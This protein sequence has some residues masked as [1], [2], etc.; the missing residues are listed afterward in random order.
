[1]NKMEKD[2][3]IPFKPKF[4]KRF[5]DDI[6]RRRKRNEPDELFDKMNSYHPNIKLTI[7]I[8]LKKFFDTK[9]LRSSN[10]IHCFMYHKENKKLIHWN[11]AV[12]KSYKRNV[13]IGDVHHAKRISCDFD[14]ELSVIKLKYIKAGYPPKFVSS[15]INTC[16]VEK[17]E[18]IIRPQMF[19]ERKTVYFQLTFC[20]TNEQKIKSIVNKLEEFTTNKVKFICHW[21]TR[22]LKSLFLLNDRI[23]RKANIVY[24]RI[25][26]CKE[27]YIGETKRNAE[28][29]MERTLF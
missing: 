7:E 2:V 16:P 27:S 13:I 1:M 21:K 20:K 5:V 26:S 10:Q 12:P 22:K 4:Y 11:S 6:Y 15:V 28:K 19:D 18:P 25:C 24:K 17:E 23:K 3:V 14:Y 9:I 29:K 8:S